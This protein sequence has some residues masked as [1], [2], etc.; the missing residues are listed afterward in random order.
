MVTQT[1]SKG[2]LHFFFFSVGRITD[3][4]KDMK[5]ADD[6]IVSFFCKASGYPPLKFYWE[7]AGKRL[8]DRK[9]GRYQVF[10]MPNGTVLRIQP[11]RGKRDNRTFTCVATNKHG[12]VRASAVL[13]VY[14]SSLTDGEPGLIIVDLDLKKHFK[15]MQ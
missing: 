6:H 15:G 4:P 2:L 7:K 13:S 10:S 1:I 8:G 11:V 9:A 3:P 12:E 14:P 5:V